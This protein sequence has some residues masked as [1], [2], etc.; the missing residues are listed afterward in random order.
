MKRSIAVQLKNAIKA[1]DKILWTSPEKELKEKLS[2]ERS[3]LFLLMK[4]GGWEIDCISGYIFK[5]KGPDIQ[6]SVS[7]L[8]PSNIMNNAKMVVK[9]FNRMKLDT[10][11]ENFVLFGLTSALKVVWKKV[12]FMGSDDKIED[13]NVKMLI[14]E[15][16][17]SKKA[18]PKAL[19]AHN[20]PSGCSDPSESD[21]SFTKHCKKCFDMLDIQFIDHVIIGDDFTSM[22]EQNFF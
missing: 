11:R 13:V 17:M 16:L 7:A 18:C 5:S 2:T 22:K 3:T 1:L 8:P 12:M 14:R 6:E 19:V 4:D 21:I 10:Q 20:H 15:L 9:H